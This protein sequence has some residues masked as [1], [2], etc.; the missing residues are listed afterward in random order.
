MQSR[1]FSPFAIVIALTFLLLAACGKDNNNT[2][3]PSGEPLGVVLEKREFRYLGMPGYVD[4]LE[5]A[6]DL[7]YLAPVKLN[8]V[9]MVTGGPQGIQVLL[10]GDVDISGIAFTGVVAKV[11]ASGAPVTAVIAAFGYGGEENTFFGKGGVYVREESAIHGPR[12]LVGKKIAVN[13]L[14]A[15]SEL[16][17]RE[18]MRRGGLQKEEIAQVEFLVIPPSSMEQ[19]LRQRQVD[20]AESMGIGFERDVRRLF[21]VEDLYQNFTAGAY[22]MSNRYL[23]ENPNTSRHVISAMAKAI[24][25]SKTTPRAEVQARFRQ[26][27][28]KR[29]RNEGEALINAWTGYG[30]ISQGG[31]LADK[32]FQIWIDWFVQDG[33]LEAGSVD[34]DKLYT[35][36]FNTYAGTPQ[37]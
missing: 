33:Q 3:P 37:P 12:D 27:V 17:L 6:E 19:T 2:P 5:L 16:L 15:Q 35:N 18:Y 34:A 31:V 9:G 21:R 14:G 25:W 11:V 23:R 4:I 30:V 29:K 32:D 22:L 8:H 24:E 36:A 7:G 28:A 13:A 1:R 26:I 20:V 10:S